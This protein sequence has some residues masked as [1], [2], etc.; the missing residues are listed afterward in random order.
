[1][2]ESWSS[3]S[4]LGQKWTWQSRSALL[5]TAMPTRRP[6]GATKIVCVSVCVFCECVVCPVIVRVFPT[7]HTINQTPDN[8]TQDKVAVKLTMDTL[9]HGLICQ[10]VNHNFK[11][12]T[13]HKTNNLRVAQYTVSSITTLL[14]KTSLNWLNFSVLSQTRKRFANHLKVTV[15]S[16]LISHEDLTMGR[17][18]VRG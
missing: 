11:C 16:S 1:M 2:P 7:F 15:V 10:P 3:P 8:P 18:V 17:L 14:S 9:I 13:Q 4:S 6:T 5:S 12:K